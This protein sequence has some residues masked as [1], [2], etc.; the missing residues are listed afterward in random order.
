MNRTITE[1]EL[2]KMQDFTNIYDSYNNSEMT[3]EEAARLLGCSERHFRRKR[4][5]YRSYHE[6]MLALVDR[7]IGN[8]PPNKVPCYLITEMLELYTEKYYDFNAKHFH[9]KLQ[10]DHQK[11]YSYSWVK[12]MLQKHKLLKKGTRKN[13][14]RKKRDRRPREGMMLHQDASKHKWL[15]NLDYLL[16][17]VV[18]MDDASNEIYSIFLID[19]EG[20][21]STFQGLYETF[22]IKGLPMS[23]YT[24][25]GSHYI[26]TRDGKIDKT[27]PTQVMR[28]LKQLS[29]TTIYAYT[30]QAR[31]RSERM[32]GTLQG[33]LPQEFR[34]NNITNIEEANRFLKEKFLPAF[35]EEFRKAPAFEE[36]MFVPYNSGNLLDILSIQSSRVVQNDNTVSYKN[37]KLQIPA[38]QYR[39]HYTKC[40]VRIHE[41]FNGEIAI[42]YGPK[43][44]ATYCADGISIEDN[45][46]KS[47]LA[48]A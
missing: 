44:L 9:I 3:C 47:M 13:P 16:D 2:K 27:N 45:L 6:D 4:D 31:G 14:H 11:T 10:Q 26:T 39:H 30:P 12:S 5:H 29:V 21:Q 43:K 23:F 17:L 34:V 33:R 24:D 40:E 42:F 7:R 8:K 22:I 32:F 19:E 48:A 41:Y 28:A 15:T 38:N 18:T 20:T 37:M 1:K 36:S 25:R 35:N 46:Q